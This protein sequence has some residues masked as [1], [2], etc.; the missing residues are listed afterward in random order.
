MKSITTVK[1]RYWNTVILIS[2]VLFSSFS[3]GQ[4]PEPEPEPTGPTIE[5]DKPDYQPGE[6]VVI[7]GTGWQPGE[8]VSLDFHEDPVPST[9]LLPHDMVAVA[10][11]FGNIY[12]NQFLVK[13]NH[14]GVTFTLTATGQSSGFTAQTIFTDAIQLWS[15]PITG[16][17]PNTANPYTA[18]QIVSSFIT[19]SGI[20]RGS[21]INGANATDRYS[22]DNWTTSGS[23]NTSDYFYFIL[24][25]NPG[26]HIRFSNFVYTAQ[27]SGSGPDNFEFRSNANGNNFVTD[28]GNPDD[29]GETISLSASQ[30]QNKT[31]ATEFRLYGFDA[32]SSNGTFSVNSFVF[33]GAVLG[34]NV[35]S[36][37]GF[38]TCNNAP[39]SAQFFIVSGE[40]L[41]PSSTVV[42]AP[43]ANFEVSVTSAIAGF[44]GSGSVTLP[45]NALGAVNG[46]VWVRIKTNSP[47][48]SLS[49]QNIN[50]SGAGFLVADGINVSVSGT[51]NQIVGVTTH[52]QNATITYGANTGFSVVAS[53]TGPFTYQWQVDA[54]GTGSSFTNLSLT[55]IYANTDAS[56]AT[57]E[58]VTP[59]ASMNGYKYRVIVS[60]TCSPPATSN[61]AN[62][63][64]NKANATIVVNGYS[65]VYDGLAHG[66][67]GSAS[68]VMSEDLSSGLDLG[69]SFT[70]VPGGVAN[71]TFSG[72]TNYNDD[73]GSVN[74]DISK[75]NAMIVVNG[76]TGVYDGAAHGATGSASGVMS[77]DLS[78]GLDLGMSFTDVPG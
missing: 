31:T 52:P 15:N 62:L 77:E 43:S 59:S 20:G 34:R 24:T 61:P 68:G 38:V 33:N 28:I 60:G 3:F 72:G 75:A 70:D 39:S 48:G 25:P 67:T 6:Y 64:V 69:M 21:G 65:G 45:T 29:N 47:V 27:A 44:Q 17:N 11:E 57:L 78:S 54:T 42:I 16:S 1:V 18:G 58:I 7:T 49:S 55:G 12:N 63:V 71:W 37:S 66:A 14:L 35:S 4:D 56:E 23:L 9:C 30:F 51:V 41:T 26:Y 10:D 13:L 32:N 46:T 76:Y 22:A 36:L 50:I 19:V 8:T 74:I 5:T 2:L 53:G 73:S 40:G